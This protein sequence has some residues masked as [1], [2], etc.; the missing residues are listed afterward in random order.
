MRWG[1][2]EEPGQ[3][4]SKEAPKH[5]QCAGCGRYSKGGVAGGYC[6]FGVLGPLVLEREGQPIPLPSGRQRSLL[7]LL[8]LAG[9]VPLS[10]DRLIDELWGERPPASAVSALHVHLSK[11]RGLLDGLLVLEPAGYALKPGAFEIDVWRFDGLME[12][13]S[14]D[15]EQ[16]GPL[17]AE[18]LALFRGEPLCDVAA[19]GSIARWRRALEEKRL[20]AQ[21]LRVDSLLAAGKAGELVAELE[22]LVEEHPYEEQLWGQLILARYRAGRQAE[23]LET[24]QRVR[25]LL[26]SELGLEPGEPLTRLQQQILERDPALVPGE[27]APAVTPGPAQPAPRGPRASDVPL[28]P[29]RL[30]GREEDVAALIGLMA[31]PDVRLVTITGPGGV[32]KTRLLLELARRIQASYRDGAAFVRLE[33]LTDP[34]LVPAE[35]A[36]ALGQRDGDDGP[37]ADGLIDYLRELELLL[38]IDNFEHLLSASMLV[39]ELLSSASGVHVVTTSRTAL[40]IRGEQVFEVEPLSLPAGDT[41]Q[42]VSES[43]AVQLFLQCA[44]AANRR[45]PV[46]PPTCLTVARICRALDGLPLA[47]ELAAARAQSM[48]ADRI[49][50]ELARPL[51]IGGHA[52]RDLPSR[53][54]TLQATISWS[55]DLL[56]E[57]TRALLCCAAVFLGGFSLPALEAV[58]G[59]PV[60]PSLDELLDASLV[61]RHGDGARFELLELVRAFALAELEATG[62][63]AAARALHRRY[64]ASFVA[65]ASERFDAG[66]APGEVAAPLRADHAN[67]RAALEN[68]LDDGDQGAAVA[69]ALGLRPIWLAGMLR[70]EASELIGRVLDEC[71]VSGAIEISLLRAAAFLEGFRAEVA[72]TW[73]SR[74]A[75][76]AAELGDQEAQVTATGN[77]FARALN[78][79]NR[80]EMT[81][82]RPMLLALVTPQASP[83]ALGWLHYFLALDAYVDG[84]F[85]ESREHAALSVDSARAIGHDYMLGSAAGT[86]L[87]AHSA[88]EGAIRQPDLAATLELMARP[89]I[90]PLSIFALYLVS[91]YAAGLAPREASRWLAQA[92]R[93]AQAT[94]SQLWPESTLRDETM[95]VLNIEDLAGVLEREEPLDHVAA[96][97]EAR[98]W[99]AGRDPTEQGAREHLSVSV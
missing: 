85:E 91:R 74:M 61:R 93:I 11:L 95:A 25:R 2:L 65:Q 70:L 55:Y 98:A 90:A 87:L 32:G 88:C 47:V 31:D 13:A 24:Y 49:A 38:V 76:R 17:L 50:E 1:Q 64:F 33:R 6:S 60:D 9:G 7:A 97:A 53:Q 56:G 3:R 22:Q 12:Q 35:I 62:E 34:T 63:L 58:A 15:P 45:F 67:I 77:L 39:A 80:A 37:G 79:R 43:P 82:L 84:R 30:V 41:E 59:Q 5:G 14:A 75:A 10:R 72:T 8:L 36:S 23:A 68:A 46:D 71:T 78:A 99:V 92:E 81:Q 18:A 86:R 66:A 54:Q 4:G 83:K 94:D 29:T 42:E 73:N 26:A 96:L 69:L 20:H 28:P 89:S 51:L 16:A 57:D 52:L 19:E 48:S 21:V 27:P 44:L 40:R